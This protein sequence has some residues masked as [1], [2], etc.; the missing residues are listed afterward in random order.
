VVIA[1]VSRSRLSRFS[2]LEPLPPH[3]NYSVSWDVTPCGSYKNRRTLIVFLRSE[4]RLLVTSNVVLSSPIVITL[5]MKA[6]PSSETSVL[7]IAIRRNIPEDG[8]L[9]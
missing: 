8:I 7:T 3:L 2:R 4:G 5:M 1:A 9:Q 6:L